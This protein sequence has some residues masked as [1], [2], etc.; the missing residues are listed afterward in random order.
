MAAVGRP[1]GYNFRCRPGVYQHERLLEWTEGPN[2]SSRRPETP[3]GRLKRPDLILGA[4]LEVDAIVLPLLLT[5]HDS[6][7]PLDQGAAGGFLLDTSRSP[8]PAIGGLVTECPLLARMKLMPGARRSRPSLTGVRRYHRPRIDRIYS[9]RGQ[10]TRPISVYRPDP[11][12]MVRNPGRLDHET[13][14]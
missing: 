4:T 13:D 14:C 11:R 1:P 12:T 7:A 2:R 6:A 9:S 3:P 5:A 8:T 10:S